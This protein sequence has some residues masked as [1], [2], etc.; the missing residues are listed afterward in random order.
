MHYSLVLA[1]ARVKTKEATLAIA[2]MIKR[3]KER[4][5]RRRMRRKLRPGT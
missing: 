5:R 2:K 3:R 1:E 4:I